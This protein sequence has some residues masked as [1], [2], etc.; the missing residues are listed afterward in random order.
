M[1]AMTLLEADQELR[2]EPSAALG[3]GAPK[4]KSLDMNKI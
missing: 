4:S 1:E 2:K 3:C